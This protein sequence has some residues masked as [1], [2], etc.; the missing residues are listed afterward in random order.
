MTTRQRNA[1]ETIRHAISYGEQLTWCVPD[2]AASYRAWT[3]AEATTTSRWVEAGGFDIEREVAINAP[4]GNLADLMLSAEMASLPWAAVDILA[5]EG[6]REAL[7]I[8]SYDSD[9][10]A[11]RTDRYQVPVS[12]AGDLDMIIAIETQYLG[13]L[14]Y[15]R[16]AATST[17]GIRDLQLPDGRR[18][19]YA[20]IEALDRRVM[21]IRARLAWFEAAAA[22]TV[23]PRNEY[24]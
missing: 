15:Q 9:G 8:I 3:R 18:E 6:V 12:Q 16:Q 5:G 7:Q 1:P 20:S 21:E 4:D 22:G 17:Q 2:G 11:L 10:F 14:L 24:W 23:L 19:T 13:E